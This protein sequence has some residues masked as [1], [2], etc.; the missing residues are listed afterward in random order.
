[1]VRR[2]LDTDPGDGDFTSFHR[3]LGRS[4]YRPPDLLANPPEASPADDS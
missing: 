4:L 2:H 1:M 3:A